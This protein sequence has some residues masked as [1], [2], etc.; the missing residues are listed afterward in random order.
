MQT[1]QVPVLDVEMVD[2]PVPAVPALPQLPPPPSLDEVLS[3]LGITLPQLPAPDPAQLYSG[4]PPMPP[5]DFASL[6]SPLSSAMDLLG[7]GVLEDI[8]TLAG[9]E[10]NPGGTPVSTRPVEA[11]DTAAAAQPVADAARAGRSAANSVPGGHPLS[12]LTQ[13]DGSLLSSLEQGRRALDALERAWESTAA[14]ASIDKGRDLEN[15]KGELREQGATISRLTKEGAAIIASGKAQLQLVA[16]RLAT[17]LAALAPT[18][19]TPWGQAAILSAISAAVAESQA[20][21]AATEAQLAPVTQQLLAAARP[22]PVPAPPAPMQQISRALNQLAAPLKNAA[23]PMKTAQSMANK[24]VRGVEGIGAKNPLSMLAGPQSQRGQAAL[25]LAKRAFDVFQKSGGPGG[26]F[27][28]AGPGAIP[29]SAASRPSPGATSSSDARKPFTA[30]TPH[31]PATSG[32]GSGASSAGVGGSGGATETALPTYTAAAAAPAAPPG[33]GAPA[34]GG[35]VAPGGRAVGT[36]PGMMPMAPMAPMGAA[37]AAGAAGAGGGD[38]HKSPRYL[39]SAANGAE[40]FGEQRDVSPA[41]IGGAPPSAAATGEAGENHVP[42]KDR[43]DNPD[44]Q[45]LNL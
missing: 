9:D 8:Q 44:S 38:S 29:Y 5:L 15:S 19:F 41:V 36:A 26:P 28:A 17:Q 6:L 22:V 37:G 4:I 1:V 13:L 34:A 33:A 40:I 21:V 31:I 45:R 14:T 27:G 3:A 16:S 12:K 11:A 39:V 35:A 10:E 20:I 30:R 25:S 24:A 42:G 2:V 18:A 32:L 43:P 23:A 7:S